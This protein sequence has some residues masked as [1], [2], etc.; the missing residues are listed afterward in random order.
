VRACRAGQNGKSR[1]GAVVGRGRRQRGGADSRW[2]EH[3]EADGHCK[4]GQSFEERLTLASE[5][6]HSSAAHEGGRTGVHAGQDSRQTRYA[7]TP[8][9]GNESQISGTQPTYR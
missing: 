5:K 7:V 9:F 6:N 3:C 1:V 4:C 8:T 2:L